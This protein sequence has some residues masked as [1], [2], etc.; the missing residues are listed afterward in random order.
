MKGK[1]ARRPDEPFLLITN[2]LYLI[3]GRS[4]KKISTLPTYKQTPCQTHLGTKK[5]DRGSLFFTLLR[6]QVTPLQAVLPQAQVPLL[7]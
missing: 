3:S 4:R 1:K 7:G 2:N 5:S 6:Q